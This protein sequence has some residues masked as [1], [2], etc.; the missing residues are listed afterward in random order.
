MNSSYKSKI[1]NK[2]IL[3]TGGTGSF[4]NTVTEVL[5]PL[6]PKRIIIFSRDEKKQFD[7]RNH[8]DNALL[9]FIIGDVR[10]AES[11]M[12]AMEHVDYVFHAAALKQVP[13]CEF[14]PMEAVKTNVIGTQNVLE[15]ARCHKVKRVV[16]LST[17][18]AVYPINAL[19]MSKAMMEK[20]MIAEAKNFVDSGI[21]E[22]IFCGVR[23]GN[24]L[25]TRGSIL[26]EFMKRMKQKKKLL[27]TDSSMT[28]FLLPLSE[29]VDL[30]LY[31][32]IYGENGN[33]YVRKSPASTVETLV[34]AFCSLFNYK[35]G[36][37]EV[38]IRAGE[39]MHETL[40]A[41]EELF[42]AKD[43]GKYYKIP[44]ESQGLDYNKYFIKGKKAD[45]ENLK[46]FTSANT[47]QLTV[48]ET[49]K[50]L[51]RVPEIKSELKN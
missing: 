15:A 11:I 22:T 10:D 37:E 19:G 25:Y 38:G 24:V 13:T 17:D 4:G 36:Y 18:K 41:Q 16:V 7:M 40:V 3:I 26:P 44:S 5:L 49:K 23:Y 21:T 28:R 14:F 51:L 30:V 46:A 33:I 2:T 32:L 42:R 31:A 20:V 6:Q 29:A 35:V 12:R 47:K 50:M 27:L 48:D 43:V 8:F 9:K 1:K 34:K 39:K 45:T